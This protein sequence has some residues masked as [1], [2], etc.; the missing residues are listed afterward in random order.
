VVQQKSTSAIVAEIH[1]VGGAPVR[2]ALASGEY[3]T[4][5]RIGS[6]VRSCPTTLIDSRVVAL[7]LGLAR[8]S[9]LSEI[10]RAKGIGIGAEGG[11]AEN[12][13]QNRDQPPAQPSEGPR[14]R[15]ELSHWVLELGVGIAHSD[16]DAYAKRLNNFDYNRTG[17]STPLRAT[18]LIARTFADDYLAIGAEVQNLT[19]AEFNRNGDRVEL[20]GF[21]VAA[22]VRASLPIEVA[23]SGRFELY[24]QPRLGVAAA[25]EAITTTAKS[26]DNTKLGY[27]VGGDVGLSLYG[28]FIGGFMSGGYD[29]APAIQN[30]LSD[31][32]NVG[33]AHFLTGV[34]FQAR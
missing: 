17:S 12:A 13:P 3:D 15:S 1:K 25:N 24:A 14:T 21:G 27:L 4:L 10:T 19:G 22:A 28:R 16:N 33:G 23:R 29:Y 30:A 18:G 5:V 8:C 32:H 6:T 34:R 26:T 20:G 11:E 7:D 9:I 31:R 2:L